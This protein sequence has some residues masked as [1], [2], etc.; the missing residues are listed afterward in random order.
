MTG[1]MA[2]ISNNRFDS[3]PKETIAIKRPNQLSTKMTQPVNQKD[4]MLSKKTIKEK[5]CRL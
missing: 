5:L 4:Y 3:Q 2:D 1:R